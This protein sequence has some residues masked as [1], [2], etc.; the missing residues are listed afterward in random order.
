MQRSAFTLLELL[1]VIL[2]IVILSGAVFPYVQQYVDET[3]VSRVKQDLDEISKALIRYE[4]DQRKLYAAVDTRDLIGS[5]I[6]RNKPDP[7]GRPYL[8]NSLKS[9]CYSAGPDGVENTADD[10]ITPFRPPLAISRCLWEDNNGTMLADSGDNLVIKFT[11]PVR[12]NAGDGPQVNVLNDDFEFSE[13]A[14]DVDYTSPLEF[15][16]NRMT[17]RM[18][19]NYAVGTTPFRP[20]QTTIKVK[21]PNT[22]VDYDNIPCLSGQAILIKP[23]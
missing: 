23:K 10:V 13:G 3:R 14:P 12:D 18:Q 7:W 16:D 4:T 20:G 15:F 6:Q 8:I 9:V 19:I 22:I 5:Y 21:D 2:I 1:I 17:V 11:R